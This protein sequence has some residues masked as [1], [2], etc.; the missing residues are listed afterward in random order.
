[1]TIQKS[2]G[3]LRQRVAR[4]LA[5]GVLLSIYA[6][7][8][9]ATTGVIVTAGASSAFARGRGRGRGWGG[10]VGLGIGLGIGAAVIGGAIAAQ[11]AQRQDAIGYCMR[12]FRS[13]D[14]ESMTYLG[15][16]G[17]RHPCP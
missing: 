17:L 2:G 13:Y 4:V 9:V 12:R 1:M 6:V 7:G 16:D 10:D 14:P 11:E 8:M 5:T 15:R 3:S